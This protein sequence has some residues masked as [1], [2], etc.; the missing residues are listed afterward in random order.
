MNKG[1]SMGLDAMPP[2]INIKLAM[3]EWKHIDNICQNPA[4]HNILKMQHNCLRHVMRYMDDRLSLKEDGKYLPKQEQYG[5]AF[6][7]RVT[8]SSVVYL[9]WDISSMNGVSVKYKDKQDKIDVII[10]RYPKIASAMPRAVIKGCIKGRLMDLFANSTK[11]TGDF[12][13][14][15]CETFRQIERRGYTIEDM[16]YGI[17]DFV[18]FQYKAYDHN[19]KIRMIKTAWEKAVL[20]NRYEHNA[21]IDSVIKTFRSSNPD[22]VC[23]INCVASVIRWLTHDLTF[24]TDVGRIDTEEKSFAG[25]IARV[26]NNPRDDVAKKKLQKMEKR[27]V[28]LCLDRYVT[29]MMDLLTSNLLSEESRSRL[30]WIS[31]E[32]SKCD[33]CNMNNTQQFSN[34]YHQILNNNGDNPFGHVEDYLKGKTQSHQTNC[35][36]GVP[37]RFIYSMDTFPKYVST[38]INYTEDFEVRE[39]KV[40]QAFN[41]KLSSITY[42]IGCII[43]SSDVRDHFIFTAKFNAGADR[44]AIVLVDDNNAFRI[45][46]HND[47]SRILADQKW[48]P[49][50]IMLERVHDKLMKAPITVTPVQVLAEISSSECQD[51]SSSDEDDCNNPQTRKSSVTFA[52]SLD[53]MSSV[54]EE[55]RCLPEPILIN[56]QEVDDLQEPSTTNSHPARSNQ[57][58]DD[59]ASCHSANTNATGTNKSQVSEKENKF[60]KGKKKQ[61]SAKKIVPTRESAPTTNNTHQP[62][63]QTLPQARSNQDTDDVA[64]CH[65]ANTNATGTNKS[66]VSEKEN[67]FEKGKKKQVSAKKIVPTRSTPP[68]PLDTDSE[69]SFSIE[70][71]GTVS[72]N[73]SMYQTVISNP[74]TK[75][76]RERQERKSPPKSP[77]GGHKHEARIETTRRQHTQQ[78]TTSYNESELSSESPTSS[79]IDRSEK[80]FKPARKPKLSTGSKRERN[81]RNSTPTSPNGGEI[82]MSI[83][84]LVSQRHHALESAASSAGEKSLPNIGSRAGVIHAAHDHSKKKKKKKKK[85]KNT[86]H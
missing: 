7:P 26:V 69:A 59:V 65:S 68:V 27:N 24:Y 2:M 74:S 64:S 34:N 17:A 67:K 49:A 5:I 57:D 8:N 16:V 56:R 28:R 63:A 36:C 58:T 38:L 81:E 73:S 32:E 76:K 40:P 51:I 52:E 33:N 79:T 6:N 84:A 46:D 37:R 48:K 11:E 54:A 85:K 35:T 75:S 50:F 43:W 29:Q 71:E 4:T 82:T 61:V 14:A 1:G 77:R 66:Q 9:G 47:V 78:S 41:T 12:V 20:E 10:T 72:G 19:D 70:Q 80:T 39:A 62:T 86:V 55:L 45:P 31:N 30:T 42:Q 15:T 83:G 21:I 3:D 53:T 23:A 25:L 22:N 44:T 13:N 18:K 60:E